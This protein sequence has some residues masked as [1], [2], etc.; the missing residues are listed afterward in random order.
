LIY[1][2]FQKTKYWV[3]WAKFHVVSEQVYYSPTNQGFYLLIIGGH[4]AIL[5]NE[6]IAACNAQA[7]T[8]KLKKHT[9]KTA[10]PGS[11]ELERAGVIISEHVA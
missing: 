8:T 6:F 9:Q 1:L 2:F 10:L 4:K 7:I 11:L 3:K 5:A